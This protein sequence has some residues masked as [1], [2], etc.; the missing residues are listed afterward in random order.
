ME[1]VSRPWVAS[2]NIVSQ[3]I[4][5]LLCDIEPCVFPIITPSFISHPF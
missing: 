4:V 1:L 2:G 5:L 3:L